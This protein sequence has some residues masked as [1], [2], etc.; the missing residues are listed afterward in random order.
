MALGRLLCCT[1]VLAD[2]LPVHMWDIISVSL[3]S[4]SLLSPLCLLFQS[5]TIHAKHSRIGCTHWFC[6]LLVMQLNLMG[7]AHNLPLLRLNLTNV[8]MWHRHRSVCKRTSRQKPVWWQNFKM[9]QEA[10]KGGWQ[11][12]T[13]AGAFNAAWSYIWLQ[14][15]TVR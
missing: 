14:L 1:P 11:K 3:S 6:T 7:K 13:E 2:N 4:C 8:I 9:F 15:P 12:S 10:K 5:C